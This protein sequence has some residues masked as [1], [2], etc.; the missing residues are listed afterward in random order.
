M[1]ARRLATVGV[2]LGLGLAGCGVPIDRHPQA[3]PSS[4]IPFGLLAGPTTTSPAPGAESTA[5]LYFVD[6][7]RLQAVTRR[8]SSPLTLPEAL[9]ALLV[10][11]TRAEV[12][13]GLHT[14]LGS[15]ISL[16]WAVVV[17]STA[18]VNL[19][20]AFRRLAG[21]QR[22]LATAQLVYTSTALPGVVGMTLSVNGRPVKVPLLSGKVSGGVLTRSDFTTVAPA[23]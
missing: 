14:A 10:G 16:G 22:L 5:Q 2:A 9:T 17:G 19:S 18:H 3:I 11:P 23:N 1:R 4:Q 13:G 15:H 12:A 6:N 8:L 20:G 21:R 7:G